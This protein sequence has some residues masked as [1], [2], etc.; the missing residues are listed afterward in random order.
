LNGRVDPE[1]VQ[2]PRMIRTLPSPV[3]EQALDALTHAIVIVFRAA[4]PLAIIGFVVALAMPN[5]P[6]RSA[7]AMSAAA[8]SGD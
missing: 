4:V 5:R 6:L 7:A 1:L 2:A 8:P 3:R